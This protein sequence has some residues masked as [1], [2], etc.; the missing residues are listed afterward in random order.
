MS[1][2]RS[3]PTSAVN[4]ATAN[5]LVVAALEAARVAKFAAAVAVVDA[6]GTLRAF[7]RADGANPFPNEVAIRKAWIAATSGLSTRVWNGF[8]ADPAIAPMTHVTTIMPVA[9]G[10]PLYDHGMLIGG[11]GVSGGSPDQDDT[12]AASALAVLGFPTP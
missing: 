8:V 3:I 6:G 1:E 5:V 7:Q 9:G 2:R 4:L 12:A 10:H 11:I